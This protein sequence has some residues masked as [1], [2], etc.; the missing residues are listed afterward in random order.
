MSAEDDPQTFLEMFEGTAAACRV[1]GGSRRCSQPTGGPSGVRAGVLELEPFYRSRFPSSFRSLNVV[2]FRSGSV[3]AN[4]DLQF[5]STL[6]PNNSQIANVLINAAP[7]VTGFDIETSSI[8]VNGTASSGCDLIYSTRFGFLFIRTFIIVFRPATGRNRMT[9]TEAE[10]GIEFNRTASAG[11]I[12]QSDAVAAVLVD[13]VSNPN[14][15]FNLTIDAA[16]I[17][18]VKT[19]TASPTLNITTTAISTAASTTIIPATSAAT[20]APS[21][22]TTAPSA[23]TTAASATTTT[24][25]TTTSTTT[26]ET[27][28]ARRVTFRSVGE[29]FTSDLQNPSSAAFKNRASLTK[30]T[31]EPFYR[32]AFPSFRTIT[33][34]LF[35]NGSIVTHMDVGF[36]S[37]SVP[38]GTETGNV[39]VGAASSI[40]AFD[41]DTASIS[42][43][44]TQVSSGVSH[45]ISLITASFLV[46]LSWLLSSPQ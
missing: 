1:A 38:N 30:T 24:P 23:A 6:A 39:L 35:S 7:N 12:P 27:V 36:S 20:T 22:A 44:G 25:T 3:I 15:T 26:A 14:S 16:S 40:T 41:I 29:T 21:A 8:N 45:K 17:T 37:T 43:D 9:N 28:I 46:L 31:L 4:M 11:P 10:V 2:S 42:V 5:V 33:V 13:A 18:V 32:R 19:T 34:L